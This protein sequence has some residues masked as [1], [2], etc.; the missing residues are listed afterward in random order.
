MIIHSEQAGVK[1]PLQILLSG[2]DV[3]SDCH[4]ADDVA[5]VVYCVA[6]LPEGVPAIT[7][8]FNINPEDCPLLVKRW[9]K[10]EIIY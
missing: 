4:F 6:R 5:G 7:N 1:K 2:E 3:L 9:G 10:V 8:D